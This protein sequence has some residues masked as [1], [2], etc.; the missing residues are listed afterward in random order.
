MN[1]SEL[2]DYGS[3]ILKNNKVVSY[4]LDTEVILSSILNISRE[5]L[6]IKEYNVSKEK[7]IKFK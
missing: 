7:I 5:S 2:L 6:L 3:K 1:T 4:K